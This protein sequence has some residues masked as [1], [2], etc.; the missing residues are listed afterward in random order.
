LKIFSCEPD[1]DFVKW[2]CEK[3]DSN[4]FKIFIIG[5]VELLIQNLSEALR[6]KAVFIF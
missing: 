5:M 2:V 1:P 6:G 3:N 4:Q